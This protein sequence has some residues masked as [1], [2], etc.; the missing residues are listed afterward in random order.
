MER[1]RHQLIRSHER[2]N[3]Q[4][5]SLLTD[6][7]TVHSQVGE[8][9]TFTA[10]IMLTCVCVC[11]WVENNLTATFFENFSEGHSTSFRFQRKITGTSAMDSS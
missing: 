2:P 7:L 5:Y 3:S 4:D 9:K 8:L 6:G 1:L 10:V 11:K